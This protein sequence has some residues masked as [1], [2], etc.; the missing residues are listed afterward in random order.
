[1]KKTEKHVAQGRLVSSVVVGEGV[2]Q[3]CDHDLRPGWER[4]RP[5]KDLRG[6]ICS[7]GKARVLGG[8]WR[9]A[10]GGGGRWT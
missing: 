7:D 2:L 1:M 9:E 4:S 6:L 8:R 5:G 3:G 10:E